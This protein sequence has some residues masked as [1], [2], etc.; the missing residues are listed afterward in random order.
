MAETRATDAERV[1][2]RLT[3]GAAY[4]RFA[5]RVLVGIAL[6][7]LALGGWFWWKT[8]ALRRHMQAFNDDLQRATSTPDNGA[9]IEGEF[10][11]EADKTPNGDTALR[12][13]P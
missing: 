4:R 7:G 3:V 6:L 11:R 10:A 1:Q 5:P 8:R 9:I 12:R 2:T 13:L